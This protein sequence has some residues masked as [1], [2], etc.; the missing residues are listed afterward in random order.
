MT[1]N[2]ISL[3]VDSSDYSGDGTDY[4]LDGTD[5]SGDST[6]YT[7]DRTSCSGDASDYSGEGTDCSLDGS[8]CSGD[9]TDYSLD[10]TDC[11]GDASDYS[12]DGSDCSLVDISDS[13]IGISSSQVDNSPKLDKSALKIDCKVLTI[14]PLRPFAVRHIYYPHKA[15]LQS[16]GSKSACLHFRTRNT[17]ITPCFVR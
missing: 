13:L 8:D 15:T 9:S 4:S 14:P 5:C 1:L 12:L 16:K 2:C 3:N 10:D 7:L 17:L 6:D 11:S